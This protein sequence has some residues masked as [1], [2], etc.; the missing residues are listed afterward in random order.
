M[1]SQREVE[2]A[3]M[4]PL[5]FPNWPPLQPVRCTREI[6]RKIHFTAM[7]CHSAV[8][9]SG[10][11]YLVGRH[12][13]K[14]GERGVGTGVEQMWTQTCGCVHSNSDL[15]MNIVW[16]QAFRDDKLS[17]ESSETMSEGKQGKERCAKA[18]G[19]QQDFHRHA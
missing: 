16:V 17:F 12:Q 11:R 15:H 10:G 13:E 5:L 9:L 2:G 14:D 7:M 1:S 19:L 3:G 4:P 8:S 6:S 18:K